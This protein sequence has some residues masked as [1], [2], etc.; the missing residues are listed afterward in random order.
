MHKELKRQALVDSLK[1]ITP[2]MQRQLKDLRRWGISESKR[3]D[4]VWHILLQSFA[5]WGGSRGAEGLL[6]NTANYTRVTFDRLSTLY[7]KKREETL[8]KVFRK[9]GIR[10]AEKKAGLMARNY[11]LVQEMGG[12]AKAKKLALAQNGK[13]A[14]ITFM[15]RFHGIGDK[16]ARNIWMDVYHPDFHDT[17]AIDQRIKKVTE[18]LGHTFRTYEQEE[19]FYQGIAEEASLQG[20]ELDRLLYNYT[21]HFVTAISASGKK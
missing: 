8:R 9:A 19:S 4:F 6:N 13:E 11:D 12:I 21:D 3:S 10:Y 7:P 15:K 1:H 5:T 16:Y 17:I 2:E 18:A 14:K 20:W